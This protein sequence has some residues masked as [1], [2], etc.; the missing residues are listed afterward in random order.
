MGWQIKRYSKEEGDIG[1]DSLVAIMNEKENLGNQTMNLSAHMTGRSACPAL[2]CRAE[3]RKLTALACSTPPSPAAAAQ[4]ECHRRRRR[5][6]A[7]FR[8]R[9]LC[10][11]ADAGS[12][13]RPAAACG[14]AGAAGGQAGWG[15]VVRERLESR[16]VW[17]C[18]RG[19]E[20]PPNQPMPEQADFTEFLFLFLPLFW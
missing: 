9:G 1:V 13:V 6:R 19:W 11:A 2:N 12:S 15:I 4:V 5:R 20:L 8:P 14:R 3:P 16:V 7:G 18:G 17:R 10:G